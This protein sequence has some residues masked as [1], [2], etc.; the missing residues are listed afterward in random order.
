M[1]CLKEISRRLHIYLVFYEPCKN[2]LEV[3]DGQ[4]TVAVL[5]TDRQVRQNCQNFIRIEFILLSHVDGVLNDFTF[6]NAF[7]KS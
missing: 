6:A 7:W 4:L 2:L 5:N 3:S 1:I